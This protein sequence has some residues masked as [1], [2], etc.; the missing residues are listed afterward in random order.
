MEHFLISQK[1]RGR[2]FNHHGAGF[3]DIAVSGD[4]QRRLGVLLH[5]KDGGSLVI[6]SFNDPQYLRNEHW[7]E[8]HGGFIQDEQLGAR[9]EGPR[10]RHHLLFPAAQGAGQL[11]GSCLEERKYLVHPIKS[12]LNF[13]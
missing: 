9:H 1:I 2:A 12:L 8:S 11:P 6:Q 10:D 4:M 3:Q 13:S 7:G 5:Q